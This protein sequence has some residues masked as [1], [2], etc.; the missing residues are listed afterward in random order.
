MAKIDYDNERVLRCEESDGVRL[1]YLD[2]IRLYELE[3]SNTTHTRYI[4]TQLHIVHGVRQLVIAKEWRVSARGVRKW[5]RA[6]RLSGI[7]GLEDKKKGAGI[8]VT[9][10]VIKRILTLRED[11]MGVTDI[12]KKIGLSR[13]TVYDVINKDK[14]TRIQDSLDLTFEDNN[15]N[16]EGE[17][18]NSASDQ[19]ELP[20]EKEDLDITIS[21]RKVA[22]PLN[23]SNDR[24]EAFLGLIEDADPIFA[25]CKHVEG[26]GSML[27]LAVLTT[28]SFFDVINKNYISLGAAFY[29]LRSVFST[30]FLMATLRI[31]SPEKLNHFN[32]RKVGRLLG[33]DRSP[34]V[35]IL[36]SKM[37]DLVSRNKAMDVM[38]DLAI[39]KMSVTDEVDA[40]LYT[41]GHVQCYYGKK[42][43]GKVFS[44]N[45]KKVVRGNTD[46][47]VNLD[48]GTP[49][50][51]IPT[52]FNAHLSTILPSIIEHAQKVC[53]GK[54]ITIIFDR[55]GAD[56][57][58]Y[59]KIL[60]MGCD[61][62]AYHK[63][64]KP[65]DLNNFV[66]EKTCVHNRNYKYALL[67]REANIPVYEPSGKKNTRVKTKRTVDLREI[68]IRRDDD[69]VTH[70]ITSRRDLA[71][72]VVC[73]SL[74]KRWT[75]ENF[76]KYMIATY[77][78]DHLY[79]YK[80]SKVSDEIDHPNPEYTKLE[81]QQRKLRKKIGSIVG[82]KN[83]EAIADKDLD[84]LKDLHEG[85][86]GVKLAKLS[87]TLKSV[88][89]T[90]KI[91]P[92]R[93]SAEHYDKLD[94]E[95]RIIGNTVKSMAYDVEG[96]L[97]KMVRSVWNGVNGSE[98]SI[99]EG[100]LQST[101]EIKVKNGVLKIT[102]QR[103]ATPELTRLLKHVCDEVTKLEVKYPSS[104]LKMVFDIAK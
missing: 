31:K 17:I 6:F 35:K 103:Q 95:S 55:G 91:T 58:T 48:D 89:K 96:K 16:P 19:V 12:S 3:L 1:V 21:Q 38:N 26:V 62:I 75:Q 20:E 7:S 54:R 2:E 102:I 57:L 9:P 92:K 67:E 73:A 87:A 74:F 23:R 56:A 60:K 85:K 15:V 47:W 24:V 11:R 10:K 8:K 80:T 30:M 94:S 44:N 61:F 66:E 64:P 46:Y 70:V 83:M 68:M 65:V 34:C 33:L 77:N 84:K 4:A 59:E 93:E 52:E 97:A 98:R 101:G 100:F 72:D 78:L 22:D 99:V 104:N 82:A 25:D 53:D 27:A 86:K 51:C 41:D 14:A 63:T 36:R 29:G 50:L 37:S 42:K 69:G 90:L 5:V 40:F 49:L 81:S 39:E 79:T 71:G 13:K 18:D 76:F 45:K 88:K 28:T 32:V 43:V